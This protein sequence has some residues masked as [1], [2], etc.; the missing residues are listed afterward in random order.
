MGE[1]IDAQDA[2]AS[3][4]A[5]FRSL[6]TDRWSS[7]HNAAGHLN[8]R[9]HS[10]DLPT[11]RTLLVKAISSDYYVGKRVEQ[12]DQKIA[13]TRSW[14]LGTLAKISAGDSEATELVIR[15][16]DE[17]YETYGWARY[18]SLEGLIKSENGQ[19][20]AVAKTVAYLDSDKWLAMLA[21][22]F[23]SSRNDPKATE[24]ILAWL[25]GP[26]TQ[27]YA[28]KALRYVPLRAAVERVCTT[29]EEADYTKEETYDAIMAL[30]G[31]PTNWDHAIKAARALSKAID[32]MREKRWKDGMRTSAIAGLGNLRV[33]S[34]GTSILE[35]LLDDNPAVVR[36]AARSVEKILGLSVT[37]MRIVEAASKRGAVGTDAY[38]RALRW[39]NRDAVAEELGNLMT[40][41]SASQQ[42]VARTLL[43]ELGGAVAFEK[44]RARTNSMKQYTEI[45]E[46]TERKVTELF[47]GS[48]REAE[49]GFRLAVIMDV[50]VFAIGVVLLVGSAAY[51]LFA[52]G[53]LG[54][55]AGVGV[56]SGTGVLSTLYGLFIANP[57]RR[58]KESVE[59]LLRVK[60]V[61]LA[62]LR[63]LHQTDQTYTRRLLDDEPISFDDL[64]HFAELIGDIMGKAVQQ[65][66]DRNISHTQVS[67]GGKAP[68]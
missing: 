17:K 65:Q 1:P 8:E 6:L 12:D 18:W 16:V 51:A 43:R 56:S 34:T 59:H 30:G 15:H 44:L 20:E 19:T 55:W 64:K 63:Q 25:D 28:L 42:D 57:R 41:G 33:E 5:I 32:E 39:L 3:A 26:D 38:A 60:I 31:I 13:R 66:F 7:R 9:M 53:G 23:L 46:K 27:R 21:T 22:A 54:K 49:S 52:T 50:V 4:A 14:L 36:E 67:T 68:E 40:T 47:E 35:E 2:T 11:L 37:V 48:V 61:F 45:L 58:V 10:I 24:R 29:V 62:Y